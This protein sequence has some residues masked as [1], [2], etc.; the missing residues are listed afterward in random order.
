M[1]NNAGT[2]TATF[3]GVPLGTYN[4]VVVGGGTTPPQTDER[5]GITVSADGASDCQCVEFSL[6]RKPSAWLVYQNIRFRGTFPTDKNGRHKPMVLAGMVP[7]ALT[8]G[9]LLSDSNKVVTCKLGPIVI[10]SPMIKYD[11]HR[12]SAD[13]SNVPAGNHTL[14]VV[15]ADG[16]SASQKIR[17]AA[18]KSGC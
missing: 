5:Y 18:T 2:W 15:T 9:G 16:T 8:V 14:E 1:S 17:I 4:L 10:E 6:R 7:A 3:V 13:F 11:G 12:W